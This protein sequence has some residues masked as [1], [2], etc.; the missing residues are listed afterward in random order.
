MDRPPKKSW[1]ESLVELIRVVPAEKRAMVA[2]IAL[3]IVGIVFL[4]MVIIFEGRL[5]TMDQFVPDSNPPD[6]NLR[7][8]NTPLIDIGNSRGLE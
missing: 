6:D 4:A 5:P 2:I 7:T 3:L 8:D 1:H